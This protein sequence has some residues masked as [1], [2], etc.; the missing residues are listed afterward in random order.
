VSAVGD[1]ASSAARVEVRGKTEQVEVLPIEDPA[2][3]LLDSDQ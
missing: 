2:T 3:L 1:T